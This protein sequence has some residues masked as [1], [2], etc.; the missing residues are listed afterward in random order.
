MLLT[1][2]V[3]ARRGP[4][5]RTTEIC[6][7]APETF[8]RRPR[9]W[10]DAITTLK[11]AVITAPDF[12]YR[13]CLRHPPV[14]ADFS[15]VRHAIVGSE[16]VRASTLRDLAE[17]FGCFGLSPTALSPAYGMAEV[18]L[19]ASIDG[20]S[21]SWRSVCLDARALSE[22]EVLAT[23]DRERGIE[24]AASGPSLP[25]YSVVG[26]ESDRVTPLMVAGPSIGRDLETGKTLGSDSG[27]LSTQDVGFTV[28]SHVYVLGRS[29]DYVVVAGRNL[30]AP[31]IECSVAR[32]PEIRDER[33]AVVSIPDGGWALLCETV[34]PLDEKSRDDLRRAVRRDVINECGQAPDAINFLKRH[35][36]PY[37]TSGKL[38]RR[39][40]AARFLA[41]DLRMS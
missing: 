39:A 18:G 15:N 23:D 20:P 3:A 17:T 26:L 6:L 14:A 22:G 30:H 33:A 36:I 24:I 38:M 28:D 21:D 9:T 10:Y 25:G 5:Q 40:L 27:M 34:R 19:A 4:P 29:D 32:R 35:E 7:I 41:G 12:G 1:P 16:P 8:L 13:Y 31:S 11:A 2:L 37:T